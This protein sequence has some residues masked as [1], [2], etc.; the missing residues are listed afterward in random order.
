[1]ETF[2]NNV[3]ITQDP[4]LRSNIENEAMKLVREAQDNCEKK[5]SL[6]EYINPKKQR[7]QK[8]VQLYQSSAEKYKLINEWKRAGM[9]YENCGY[10]MQK[11]NENPMPYFQESY[12]CYSRALSD[13]DS[14]HIVDEMCIHLDKSSDLFTAGNHC[15]NYAME[16]EKRKNYTD[17]ILFY[18]KALD[19]Y[20]RDVNNDKRQYLM[21]NTE[22]KLF[23]LMTNNSH[24]DAPTRV[25]KML[26]D[27]G[28]YCLSDPTKQSAAKDYFG[29]S[30]LSDIY[31]N[32][33]MANTKNN[34]IKYKGMDNTFGQSPMYYL[35]N[36]IINSIENNNTN[37]LKASIQQY[38][39]MNILDPYTSNILDKI[40]EKSKI[41]EF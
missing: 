38:R 6:T 36:D 29:K 11:L 35:C 37:K 30:I 21:A 13:A 28:T 40:V 18:N 2:N 22:A 25:P 17:A 20:D 33:N 24:P 34:L 27:I 32:N 3:Q 15:E 16:L 39:Q 10:V 19:Y 41:T 12:N 8:A 4:I 9:S 31:Y 14:R 7:Y 23:E 5:C 26:E 1:M